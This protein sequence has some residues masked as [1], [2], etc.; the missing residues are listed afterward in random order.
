MYLCSI[1][2][3]WG[4]DTRSVVASFPL[5]RSGFDPTSDGIYGG[6]NDKGGL[7]PST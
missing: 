4:N 3:L 6:K 2:D 5:R 1:Y 7:L